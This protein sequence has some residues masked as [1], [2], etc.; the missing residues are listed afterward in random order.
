MDT[1]SEGHQCTSN[2]RRNGCPCWDHEHSEIKPRA[3]SNEQLAII[4]RI[5]KE[6]I[7]EGIEG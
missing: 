5:E 2:C 6:A 1:C 7:E 4:E 3:F